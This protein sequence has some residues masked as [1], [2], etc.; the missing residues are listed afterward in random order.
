MKTTKA[1]FEYFKKCCQKWI[2]FWGLYQFNFEYFHE[3]RDET[4]P[5]RASYESYHSSQGINIYLSTDWEVSITKEKIDLCAF[6]EI[7]ELLLVPL[8]AKAFYSFAHQE[9]EHDTHEIIR[10][11]ENC[12]FKRLK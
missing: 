6:H 12:V 1:D 7:T 10:R 8:R 11:L 3:D 4:V 5:A 9:I 2:D